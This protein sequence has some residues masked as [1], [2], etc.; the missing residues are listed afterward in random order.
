M[1]IESWLGAT[2]LKKSGDASETVSTTEALAGA[3][4][5][6]V[7]FSAHVSITDAANYSPMG[8]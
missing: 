1:S 6:G 5:I 7:Y 4:Y 2:L 8:Y 3:E